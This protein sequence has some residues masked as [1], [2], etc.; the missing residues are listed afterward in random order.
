MIMVAVIGTHLVL[1]RYSKESPELVSVSLG[2]CVLCILYLLADS[3]SI[4]GRTT[5]KLE[6]DE[7]VFG[8]MTL[9]LDLLVRT[10][11]WISTKCCR[12]LQ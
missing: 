6:P 7:Y 10:T 8:A 1:Y 4:M 12:C 9:Y 11:D 3:V 5:L 2:L